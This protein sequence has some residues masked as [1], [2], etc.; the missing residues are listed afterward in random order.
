MKLSYMKL[1]MDEMH[2]TSVADIKNPA[3]AARL[4]EAGIFPP[5]SERGDFLLYQEL[6]MDSDYVDAHEDISYGKE[7]V[8]LHSHRFWEIIYVKSGNLQYLLGNTRYQ[9]R[10]DH[11]VII[12]P[13][14]SHRPLFTGEDTV[15]YHRIVI[16]ISDTFA[17][18]IIGKM[19]EL[20][21]LH[22]LKAHHQYVLHPSG[23]VQLELEKTC[24]S[25]LYEKTQSRIGNE[26]SCLGMATQL[27]GLF[28]RAS[29]LSNS[30]QILPEKTSLL[31]EILHY[32]ETH[33]SDTISLSSIAEHFLVSQSAISH[34]FKKQMDVSFYQVVIQRRLIESKN[35]ILAGVPLKEIPERCGFSDYSVFYKAFVKE[36][37]ISPKQYKIHEFTTL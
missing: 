35:L 24:E 36:Y 18:N 37:G 8:S 29:Y 22:L 34:M 26:I 33:L 3:N 31:D 16:W 11:L 13:G 17:Q 19:Q 10:A 28:C 9:L 4:Q 27:F 15:P 7:T 5:Y 12:P 2:I 20:E 6:E 21:P 25:L 1:L 30:S 32:I 23:S 14:M